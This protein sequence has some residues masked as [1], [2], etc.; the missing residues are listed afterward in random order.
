MVITLLVV[1][2]L[3][4]ERGLVELLCVPGEPHVPSV[5]VG[6]IGEEGH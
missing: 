1:A 2:G 6:W 4:I 5:H 3:L